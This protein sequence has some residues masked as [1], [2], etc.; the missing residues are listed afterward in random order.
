MFE[1]IANV[2]SPKVFFKGFRV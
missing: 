1:A 2:R